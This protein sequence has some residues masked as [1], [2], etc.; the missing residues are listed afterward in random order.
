M[1]ATLWS[2]YC[3]KIHTSRWRATGWSC[4]WNLH[5]THKC[6]VCVC[7][8]VCGEGQEFKIYYHQAGWCMQV[9]ARFKASKSKRCC[10]EIKK[11]HEKRGRH[12][13]S[14]GEWSSLWNTLC[15][16][17]RAIQQKG[18]V[19]ECFTCKVTQQLGRRHIPTTC[20]SELVEVLLVPKEKAFLEPKFNIFYWSSPQFISMIL[21]HTE[22][23]RYRI[24]FTFKIFGS[25]SG[26]NC[27]RKRLRWWPLVPKFAG[28]NPAEAVGFFSAKKPSTRLP[29]EG[30]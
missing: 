20:C 14:R 29:S 13:T 17:R 16:L 5:D 6:N 22:K 25:H 12:F 9:P 28:S 18:K 2:K 3:I 4:L 1:S 19:N 23:R 27:R 21:R 7:V 30:K 11:K 8:C 10:S 15:Q 26:V 24:L